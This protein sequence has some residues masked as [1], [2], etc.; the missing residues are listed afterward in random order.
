V[1]NDLWRRGVVPRVRLEFL[2][3]EKVDI[4]LMMDNDFTSVSPFFDLKQI[5]DF[6]GYSSFALKLLLGGDNPNIILGREVVLKL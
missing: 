1:G 5:T 4:F 6:T 3:N 2:K